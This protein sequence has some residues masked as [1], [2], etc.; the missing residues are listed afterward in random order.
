MQPLPIQLQAHPTAQPPG[1]AAP[2]HAGGGH[3]L[4]EPPTLVVIEDKRRRSG[5]G[6]RIAQ[7]PRVRHVPRR[8][9]RGKPAV[10]A[11]WHLSL[12]RPILY[13]RRI[14]GTGRA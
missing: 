2:D 13:H 12:G 5:G 3:R 1:Q 9:G 8:L 6:E 7:R 11:N 10:D 4:A 14:N